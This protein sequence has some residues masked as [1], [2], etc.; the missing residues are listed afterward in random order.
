MAC[1]FSGS[2]KKC[3]STGIN[4]PSTG[5]VFSFADYNAFDKWAKPNKI[6]VELTN[7]TIDSFPYIST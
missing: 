4:H 7:S 3:C 2:V 6:E 5:Y 1:Y